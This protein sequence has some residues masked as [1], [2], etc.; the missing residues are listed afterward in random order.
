AWWATASG[1]NAG[2]SSSQPASLETDFSNHSPYPRRRTIDACASP[3]PPPVRRVSADNRWKASP[4]SSGNTSPIVLQRFYHQNQQRRS[5]VDLHSTPR[6]RSLSREHS[7]GRSPEPPPR[8]S[9]Q[10]QMLGHE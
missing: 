2:G 6:H 8:T 10:H 3:P 1:A 5:R 7:T 9:R 4:V